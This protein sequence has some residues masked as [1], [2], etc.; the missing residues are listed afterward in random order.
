MSGPHSWYNRADPARLAQLFADDGAIEVYLKSVLSGENASLGRMMGGM[1]A[2]KSTPIT[3]NATTV[4]TN[5][6]SR[7][8]AFLGLVATNAG[9]TWTATV[10]DNTAASGEIIVPSTA[11]A[12]GRFTSG[13]YNG[14]A[15]LLNTGLTVVTAGTT[16]GSLYALY[17]G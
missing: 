11:V 10:Y 16:P 15:C 4:V 14:D 2:L 7:A 9:T 1:F 13:Y 8:Q 5:A 6:G 17:I 12:L 3:T